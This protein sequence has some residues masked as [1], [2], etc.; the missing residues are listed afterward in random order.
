MTASLTLASQIAPDGPWNKVW[1]AAHWEKKLKKEDFVAVNIKESIKS[2][3]RNKSILT[4]RSM[5]H[6]LLGLCKVH[7][8]QCH[9]HEEH[10][11]EVHDS[12]LT[13]FSQ[14]DPEPRRR[15]GRRAEDK[16]AAALDVTEED[17]AVDKELQLVLASRKHL[18]PIDE[19]TLKPLTEPDSS[20]LGKLPKDTF[21][22]ISAEEKV[23]MITLGNNLK[24]FYFAETAFA[25]LEP[26][27]TLVPLDN[28][29]TDDEP[30]PVVQADP[31]GP[32][33]MDLEPVADEGDVEMGAPLEAPLEAAPEGDLQPLAA[34]GAADEPAFKRRKRGF[35]FD[36]PI[37]IPKDVYQGYINDRTSITRKD[38][39]ET[40]ILMPH[41]HPIMPQFTTTYTDMCK[42]L[43][44]CLAWGTQVAERQR[45][46]AAMAEAPAGGLEFPILDPEKPLSI[47]AFLPAPGDPSTALVPAP[48]P[49]VWKP[50]PIALDMS[51]APSHM[52]MVVTGSMDME[53]QS[54]N[55]DARV[56]YSGRTE[57]MHKFLA[58]EF[59]R[60]EIT[61]G[62]CLSYETMCRQQAAGDRGVIA[63]CFFELLVLRT[64]GVVNLQQPTPFAD[65]SIERSR[66][67]STGA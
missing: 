43:I 51:D 29:T 39:F 31:Q 58:A 21:G 37:E 4:L 56:G 16:V 57:K 47:H 35:M 33:E 62:D 11:C 41:Y 65:I 2:F 66:S 60:G 9:F 14:Q 50:P 13:A 22:A 55:T 17:L 49:A 36:D 19:I 24:K 1:F 25:P 53:D 42:S 26:P 5:G 34:G 45:A 38:E 8:K 3:M 59:K 48:E 27:Q 28:I 64:N 10:A 52:R 15:A 18:A 63:G 20:G 61:V 44:Q 23:N 46:A 54:A 40:S 67:W 12:M 7:S 6:L 32:L 30:K